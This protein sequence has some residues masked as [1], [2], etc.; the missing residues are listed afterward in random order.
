[1]RRAVPLRKL[2]RKT[3]TPA[4]WLP[5]PATRWLPQTKHSLREMWS[6]PMGEGELSTVSQRNSLRLGSFL[7][8]FGAGFVHI[9]SATRY[10]YTDRPMDGQRTHLSSS[11]RGNFFSRA[12]SF[13]LLALLVATTASAAKFTA[14][15]D[16]ENIIVGETVTLKLQFDGVNPG[17]VPQL[18]AIPGLQVA[19]AISQGSSSTIGPEGQQSTHWYS[20]PLA[21]TQAGDITIPS[22]QLDIA[23]Q[24]LATIPIKLKVVSEDPISPPGELDQK[25]AFLWLSLPK[26]ECYVGETIVVEMRLYVRP[27]VRNVGNFQPSTPQGDG[28][29]A[30]KQ[31]VQANPFVRRIGRRQYTAIPMFCTLTAIKTGPLVINPI[32]AVVI[33]NPPDV[34]ENFFSRRPNDTEQVP[35]NTERKEM[36]ALPLPAENVPPGFLSGAVGNYTMNV[37]VGPTNVATGDPVTVRV[38]IAGRGA[39]E[40]LALP[41]Q[42]TWKGFK[43]YP[44]TSTT[45]ITDQLGIQGRKR[46]E[47]VVS[48]ENTELKEIPAFKFSFFDPEVKQYKTLTFPPVPLVVRPGGNVP[49]PFVANGQNQSTEPPAAAQDIVHIK[50]RPGTF[51]RIS[52]PL[53]QQPWFIAMNCVPPLVWLAAVGWRK[54]ADALTNN[55][56]LR[57]QRQVEQSIRQ[58]LAELRQHAAANESDKFFA[59]VLDLLQEQLGER[60][61]CPASAIT[62]AVIDERLRPLGVPE[63]ILSELQELF[64]AHNLARYAPV[65]SSSEL[66]AMI[67]RIENAL[68]RV[69]EVTL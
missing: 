9:A 44:P 16:R 18:P 30:G 1:M 47:Q 17:G 4:Q 59:T 38:E 54:R 64:Q 5:K 37:A 68:A 57:R 29:T 56:R 33:L 24:R 67:P 42:D 62:E 19:G 3:L 26:T 41:E 28:F 52:R 22:F 34:F 39:I 13:F 66:N 2:S 50:T 46:F 20:I 10:G 60:L 61:D 7:N 12:A 23:G 25:S 32:N 63:E 65:Q 36:R 45:E 8:K 40:A 15:L 14:S 48:P 27:G 35:L 6:H 69:R 21:A 51:K 43:S 55:P 49:T 53:V 58:G 31:W 11:W